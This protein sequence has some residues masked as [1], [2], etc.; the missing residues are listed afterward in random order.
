MELPLYQID[1][2]TNK[3]FAGNAA[4]VV[5]LKAPLPEPVMQ[6]IA[7]ENNLPE[8]AF[9]YPEGEG[10]RL[11]WFSPTVE[12]NLCGH[13]TVATAFVITEYLERGKRAMSFET[14]SVAALLRTRSAE[15]EEQCSTHCRKSSLA[16]STA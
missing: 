9:F 6:S 12:I 16:F 11:R 14:R 10:Y 2:F 13:A 5:P 15:T 3:L 8:T 1:A 7:L 4:G